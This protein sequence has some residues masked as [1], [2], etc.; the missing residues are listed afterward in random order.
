MALAAATHSSAQPMAKV[1]EGET[2]DAPRRPKPPLP[3]KRPAPL[4]EVAEP[5]AKLRQHSGICYELV[6]ALDVP[7]HAEY[8]V[9]ARTASSHGVRLREV[10]QQMH[11]LRQKG[12][13]RKKK[14]KRKRRLPR[15]PRPRRCL[16]ATCGL[17]GPRFY[18][19]LR[20]TVDICSCLVMVVL[21]LYALGNLDFL[22]ATGTWHPLVGCL[23]RRR[24]TGNFG[25]F[26]E[27]ASRFFYDPLHLTVTCSEFARGEQDYGFF[28]KMPSGWIPYLILLGSTVDACLHQCTEAGPDCRKLWILRSCSSFWIVDICF[29]HRRGR[30]PW[31][32]LFLA[33]GVSPLQFVRVI[34]ILGMQVVQ[35]SVVARCVER[36]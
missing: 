31:S 8:L 34:E 3:G 12:R 27:T 35:V 22:R 11:V 19:L 18:A 20:S 10:S 30:F 13:G 14:K 1:V 7:L 26:W 21:S 36:Q 16:G 9:E 29:V 17:H 25:V 2:N 4:E 32:R 5:Q 15:S 23:S 6:L 28:C 24:S 33:L